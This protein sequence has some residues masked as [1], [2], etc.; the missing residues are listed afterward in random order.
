MATSYLRAEQQ[1]VIQFCFDSGMTQFNTLNLVKRDEYHLNVSQALIY[2]LFSRFR[3]G[4]P[5][6]KRMGGLPLRNTGEG[7]EV[8]SF[9][10]KDRRQR[11]AT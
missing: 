2:T 9:V 6:D 3:Q 11:C 1:T 7:A 8:E 10:S 5:A 4:N